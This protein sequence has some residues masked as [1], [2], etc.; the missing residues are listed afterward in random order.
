MQ[1]RDSDWKGGPVR[2]CRSGAFCLA[3]PLRPQKHPR[4][5]LKSASQATLR[6]ALGGAWSRICPYRRGRATTWL[7]AGREEGRGWDPCLIGMR[8]QRVSWAWTFQLH[9]PSSSRGAEV[10]LG[11]P[12]LPPFSSGSLSGRLV[13]QCLGLENLIFGGSFQV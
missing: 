10:A 8:G 3:F 4:N 2:I 1:G 5:Q 9:L 11:R 12:S 7:R 13:P 6:T